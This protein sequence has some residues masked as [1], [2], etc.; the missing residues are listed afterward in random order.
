[1]VVK[2]DNKKLV[3]SGL[4]MAFFASL[5]LFV[6]KIVTYLFSGSMLILGSA[7][8]S[9]ADSIVSLINL[10]ISKQS[11]QDADKE[12]P[13]GHGGFEVFGALIQGLIIFF[14]G[15][16][17]ILESIRKVIDPNYGSELILDRLPLAAGVLIV[18]AVTSFFIHRMLDRKNHQIEQQNLRSLAVQS[19]MAHYAGD[20][21]VNLLS[22]VSLLL[23][24]YS[25]SV[26]ADAVFGVLAGLWL[27][28]SGYPLVKKSFSDIVHTQAAPELQQEIVEIAMATSNQI[29]GLHKL[30]SRELGPLLF[31]DFHLKL[32]RELSLEIAH[33]IGD[34][35]EENIRK[36]FPN[37]DVIVHLDPDSEED[38]EEWEP[39]YTVPESD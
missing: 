38:Q 11:R 16:N 4:V 36:T 21:V 30:R 17:L 27:F 10:K 24:W 13:F 28:K 23:V 29:M 20:M 37:A 35:V 39:Q 32:P 22:S 7:L 8:D 31:V 19:D 18:S 34:N 15:Y 14:F 9:L 1:M 6:V 2:N 12:H 5:L 3:T 25:E 33:G 26:M